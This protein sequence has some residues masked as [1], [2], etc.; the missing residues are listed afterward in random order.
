MTAV[1]LVLLALS[2]KVA[3]QLSDVVLAE[4]DRTVRIDDQIDGLRVARDLLLIA[5]GESPDADSA[6]N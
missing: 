6:E 4:G 1:V 5:R 3:V 2:K